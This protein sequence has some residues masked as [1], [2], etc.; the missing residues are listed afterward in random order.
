MVRP[1]N[2][3]QGGP[4][5]PFAPDLPTVKERS[6]VWT[7][8]RYN[9]DTGVFSMSAKGRGFAD[10]GF[11]ASWIWSAGVFRLSSMNAQPLYGGAQPGDWPALYRTR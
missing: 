3:R 11:S 7:E 8:G 9:P 1:R 5:V 4:A 10:C 6:A 2:G